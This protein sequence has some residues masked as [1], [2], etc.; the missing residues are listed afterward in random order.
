MATTQLQT[1]PFPLSGRTELRRTGE[2]T[3]E[4]DC[5]G[6]SAEHAEWL[7]SFWSAMQATG[8]FRIEFGNV[9]YPECLFTEDSKE[10]PQGPGPH[11]VSFSIHV[12]PD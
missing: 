1:F 9:V 7:L 4:I 12:Q 10:W 11:N 5:I 8:R 2:R 6:I 3:I